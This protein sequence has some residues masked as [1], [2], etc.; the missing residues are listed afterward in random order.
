MKT[1][2]RFIAARAIV[3]VAGAPTAR[4]H[5]DDAPAQGKP[6]ER[7]GEVHFNVTCDDVAAEAAGEKATSRKYY[8][9]LL[10]LTEKRDAERPEIRQATMRQ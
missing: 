6:L 1:T 8:R 3:L 4:A 2:F 10:T 7:L 5:E 9:Q